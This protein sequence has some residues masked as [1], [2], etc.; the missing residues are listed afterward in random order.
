MTSHIDHSATWGANSA[1]TVTATA[2][3]ASENASA[4]PRSQPENKTFQLRAY[5]VSGPEPPAPAESLASQRKVAGANNSTS[6]AR[7]PAAIGIP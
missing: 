4:R 1:S 7:A 5:R 3:T 6:A 2:T